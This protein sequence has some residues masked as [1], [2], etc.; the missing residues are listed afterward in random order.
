MAT[1]ATAYIELRAKLDSFQRDLDKAEQQATSTSKSIGQKFSDFGS[2]AAAVGKKMTVGLTLPLAAGFG[3]ALNAASDLS[4][5]MNKVDV[6]FGQAAKGIQ[7]WSKDAA[8][9]MGISRNEALQAAGTFGNLFT[10]MEIGQKPASDMSKGL[11]QLA[12]DLASFNNAD[13]TEVL[14][15]LRSGL[16]GETEP[17]RRFGVQLSAVRVE[18]EALNMG[19]AKSGEELTAAQKAQAS[20]SIILRDTEKA[21]GDFARTSDGVANRQRIATAQ[22]KDAAATLGNNLLPI[23]QKVLGWVTDLT[24]R[25][26]KLSPDTQ[27]LILILGGL[28][29]AAGPVVTAIGGISAAIGFLAANPIVLVAA[30]VVALTVLI[31]KNWD[32]IRDFTEKTFG[33]IA[34]WMTTTWRNIKNGVANIVGNM[35]GWLTDKFASF[36][37][38]FFNFAGKI[39][40]GAEKAFGWVP[41]IG[42]KIRNF[43]D[44]FNRVTD[45]IVDDVRRQADGFRNWGDASRDNINRTMDRLRELQ[46][47]LNS[48]LAAPG[49][50]RAE[51][52]HGSPSSPGIFNTPTAWAMDAMASVAGFQAIT[53]GYRPGDVGSYHSIAPPYNAVDIGGTNLGAVAA[54]LMGTVGRFAKEIIYGNTIMERGRVGFY[55]PN[56]H[57]DHVHLADKG[58]I[59]RGPG[60][61]AM[62]RGYEMFAG[63]LKPA[64]KVAEAAAS[65]TNNWHIY[66]PDPVAVARE[67][68]ERQRRRNLM[69]SFSYA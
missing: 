20:Y 17:L 54:Y 58:G 38:F 49:T 45:R 32:T 15:A 12:S 51:F 65:T 23:G 8:T 64:Q 5:S 52:P 56:D 48:G 59:F 1:A 29:A 13:P 42:D 66:G 33:A 22:F 19:L 9:A 21:Q 3:A 30:A 10:A 63:G 44:D 39:L 27:K 11:V 36:I 41:E 62:G 50:I 18:Q 7:Q 57:W 61:V 69:A 43:R 68:D 53:S 37:D 47:L 60:L 16:V 25:F 6:V 67:V 4:E 14:D 31:V 2:K 24:G 55:P 40:T 26:N 34:E 46:K 35:L 28:A